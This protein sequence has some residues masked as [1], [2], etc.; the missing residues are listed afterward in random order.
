M[1]A[2]HLEQLGIAMWQRFDRKDFFD[3]A[4][5]T[6]VSHFSAKPQVD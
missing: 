1:L 5:E 6:N 4:F 2:V 3:I